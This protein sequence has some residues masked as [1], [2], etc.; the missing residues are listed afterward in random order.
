[1]SSIQVDVYV[2]RDAVKETVDYVQGTNAVDMVFRFRDYDIPS[3]STAAV[4]VRKPSGK[5]VYNQA[6]VSGNDVALDVTSQMFAETGMTYLQV[7]VSH[8]DD[9]LVT[10]RQPVRVSR[11]YVSAD[12]QESGNESSLLTEV[13]AATEAAGEAAE[14]ANNAAAAVSSAVAGVIND[15]QIS[16]LTTYSSTK[17]ESIRQGLQDSMDQM[18]DDFTADIA[19]CY[20]RSE[21]I[22]EANID[23]IIAGTYDPDSD[24]G[25]YD[26]SGGGSGG[27]TLDEITEA[28]I[29]EIIAGLF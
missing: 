28:E 21:E 20:Q 26:P 16:D 25:A 27:G 6:S 13:I 10:F 12:A 18:E 29:N 23:A 3:G 22:T 7:Q 2:L 4:Y 1:M 8:G 19:E 14:A 17:I 9:E 24:T 15:N 5:E 11:N